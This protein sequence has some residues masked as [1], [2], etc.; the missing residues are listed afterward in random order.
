MTSDL[1]HEEV[2]FLAA[3]RCIDVLESDEADIV[4]AEVLS[5]RF[6]PISVLRY[7]EAIETRQ[8]GPSPPAS[9]STDDRIAKSMRDK[10]RWPKR[11]WRKVPD[12][13]PKDRATVR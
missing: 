3:Q 11:A 7:L 2:R 10:P 12:G 5:G 13:W 8:N 6:D 4:A 1:D 9:G